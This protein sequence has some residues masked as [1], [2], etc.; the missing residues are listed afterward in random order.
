MPPLSLLPGERIEARLRPT[1]W[2]RLGDYGKAGL[3]LLWAVALRVILTHPFWQGH[4]PSSPWRFW[5]YA[6]GN[7]F[8]GHVLAVAGAALIGAVAVLG[9]PPRAWQGAAAV[10]GTAGL[11]AALSAP[12]FWHQYEWALPAMLVVVAAGAAGAIELDRGLRQIVFT[13][14]RLVVHGGLWHP[15]R[16]H[17]RYE[18]VADIDVHQGLLGRL[19]GYGT[20]HA[21]PAAHAHDE[22]MAMVRGVRPISEG[23]ALLAAM[24]QHAT[25]SPELKRAGDTEAHLYRAL[26]AFGH[27]P[28][29]HEGPPAGATR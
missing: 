10:G 13:N 19:F 23:R 20:L 29:E 15:E 14:I 9:Q 16:G 8:M 26:R 11:A 1:P 6:Y 28:A 4:D 21:V 27:R 3:L 24:V 5:E 12:W 22:P 2:S 17:I 25:A 7:P 18:D